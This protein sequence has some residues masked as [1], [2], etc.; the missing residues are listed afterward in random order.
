VRSQYARAA[1]PGTNRPP[2]RALDVAG[3]VRWQTRLASAGADSVFGITVDRDA[4][5]VTAVLRGPQEG[6]TVGTAVNDPDLVSALKALRYLDDFAA[7][8]T[9]AF[10]CNNDGTYTFVQSGSTFT[11]SF[12]QVGTCTA[13]DGTTFPNNVTGTP[14]TDG[15]IQGLHLSFVVD[16]SPCERALRGPTLSAMGGAGRCAGGGTFGSYRASWSATR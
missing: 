12:D 16:G 13:A 11:V 9:R 5:C 14:V 4:P 10:R 2:Q 3:T 7:Q 1:P 8:A 6:T 15:T